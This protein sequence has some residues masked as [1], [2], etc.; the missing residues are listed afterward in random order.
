MEV[1]PFL[2][3]EPQYGFVKPINFQKWFLI[4]FYKCTTQQ[5]DNEETTSLSVASIVCIYK[6]ILT[7]DL[8]EKINLLEGRIIC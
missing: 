6:E 3:I 5:T 7:P 1:L 4:C 8:Q 2:S